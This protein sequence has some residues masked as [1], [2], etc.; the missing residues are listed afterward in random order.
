MKTIQFFS[1]PMIWVA[2][3][4]IGCGGSEAPAGSTE[5]LVPNRAGIY[6][7]ATA[8]YGPLYVREV[9]ADADESFV[10]ADIQPWA[11]YW[12][13]MRDSILVKP[14]ASNG[15]QPTLE[16]YDKYARAVFGKAS[17]AVHEEIRTGLYNDRAE[18]WEGR[19]HAWAMASVFEVEPVLPPS[20][21]KVPGTD[22]TFYTRDIKALIIKAYELVDN[23][24]FRLYGRPFA[25]TE[26]AAQDFQDIYP[27][28]FHRVLQ[29]EL[30]ERGRPILM[31]YAAGNEVW[32]SPV[33]Q[34]Q[35][36]I[37]RDPSDS[38]VV[39]VRT[40]VKGTQSVSISP[41]WAGSGP[42]T[43][44]TYEYEYDLMGVPQ[45]DGR[46]LVKYGKWTGNS[47]KDH[48]DF[49]MSLP[50]KGVAVKHW[51][52]N[53]QLDLSVIGDILAKTRGLGRRLEM[54]GDANQL[55]GDF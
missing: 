38:H 45:E 13:P 31:D 21:V 30:Y 24:A 39:H 50:P 48:P 16:K 54:F 8:H 42:K 17:T 18:G 29:A 2:L 51:S 25:L 49:V 52:A 55:I 33:W 40:V 11:G 47:I 3:C 32:N 46:L 37:K 43:D 34:A 15:G 7:E 5:Y 9:S 6:T 10:T 28:Q 27:D 22:L 4:S 41:D 44:T 36:V 35:T 19:C 1:A 12:Y 26:D 20:G 14:G 53:K 23:E